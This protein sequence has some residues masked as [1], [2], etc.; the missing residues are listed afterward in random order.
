MLVIDA[1]FRWNRHSVYGNNLT[2]TINPFFTFQDHHKFFVN[3][4]NGFRVPSLYQLYSEY[5][6]RELEPEKSLSTE[7]GYHFNND[8][9]SIRFAGFQRYI[10]N[11][12]VFYTDPNTFVSQYRND[13]EQR[14]FGL[15][16]EMAFQLTSK[17]RLSGN[18][19]WVNGEVTTETIGGKDTTYNNLWRRPAHTGNLTLGW[20]VLPALFVSAHARIVSN[21][22]E[23]QYGSEPVKMDGYYTIDLHADFRIG[24]TVSLFGDLRNLTDTD[25]QDILGFNSRGFNAYGGVRFEF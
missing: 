16:S 3:V 25:Y 8:K 1:G 20:N 2:G 24:K 13:D 21:F 4:S 11:V 23:P 14:D 18:Y 12:I 5:G 9:I 7:I 19:T 22:Y 17:I 6:N 15:E 10:S